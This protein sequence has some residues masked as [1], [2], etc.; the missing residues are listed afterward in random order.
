MVLGHLEQGAVLELGL[1]QMD[2]KGP[3]H[4]SQSVIL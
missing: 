1:G 4:L 2:S 3:A